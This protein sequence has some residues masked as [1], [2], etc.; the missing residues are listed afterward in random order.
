[1]KSFRGL[2]A[3]AHCMSRDN[4]TD[5]LRR[6]HDSKRS[7]GRRKPPKQRL[8]SRGLSDPIPEAYR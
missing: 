3:V 2:M 4:W 5:S 7:R 1:M 8:K 6:Q